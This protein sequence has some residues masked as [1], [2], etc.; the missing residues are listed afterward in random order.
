ML[1][2]CQAGNR[3]PVRQAWRMATRVLP[4][5]YRPEVPSATFARALVGGPV[6]CA[7]CRLPKQVTTSPLRNPRTGHVP[8]GARPLHT[9]S[10]VSSPARA[11]PESLV[12]PDPP[13]QLGRFVP[14]RKGV[15]LHGT[16]SALPA[17]IPHAWDI[18]RPLG[19]R[20]QASSLRSG[21]RGPLVSAPSRTEI[22]EAGVDGFW[23]STTYGVH[24]AELVAPGLSRKK[25]AKGRWA[26]SLLIQIGESAQKTSFRPASQATT[27]SVSGPRT[28]L[29]QRLARVSRSNPTGSRQKF[30]QVPAKEP[31]PIPYQ[32]PLLY[33]ML[34]ALDHA[35]EAR[36]L[37]I[38]P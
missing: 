26:G 1:P 30:F 36:G 19:R 2:L 24:P 34:K 11:S 23:Y 16:S 20:F 8:L 33:G 12:R 18:A 10:E 31:F 29:G 5:G 4:F 22:A 35:E 37:V 14:V 27:G 28:F 15:S 38:Q 21:I 17:R 13:G 6:G 7:P 25:P 9:T 3:R 32:K